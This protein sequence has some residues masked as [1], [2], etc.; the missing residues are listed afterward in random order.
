MSLVTTYPFALGANT[1]GGVSSGGGGGTI[2]G[3]IQ[4][5]EVAFG[6]APDTIGG[7]SDFT[8]D[9]TNKLLEVEKIRTQVII[10]VRNETGVTI[11]AGSAVYVSADGS[12]IPLVALADASD[13]TK[14][15]SVGIVSNAINTG[16][17][18]Y[19]VLTGT[20]NGLD[21]SAGNTVF[22]S[23]IVVGDV[24]KTLYVSPTN[25]GRLTITRPTGTTELVQNV[26]RIIDLTGN[27]V[28]MAVNN[29][30]RTNDVPNSFS[31]TGNIDAGSL[32]VNSAFTFPTSDGASGQILVTDG[33][34]NLSF[35]DPS[36]DT[37]SL[38]AD[39]TIAI[40]DT[41]RFVTS[42]DVG[43][44]AGRVIRSSATTEASG[45]VIGIAK[46]S[47]IQGTTIQVSTNGSTSISFSSA[48]ATSDNGKTIYLSTTT[49]K[50]T[51]IAPTTTGN[52]IVKLGKVYGADGLSLTPTCLLSIDPIVI[53][54]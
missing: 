53:L 48:P 44:T 42:A 17:N 41:L 23:T 28:K 40:G 54:G 49:G 51:L 3:T 7:A 29:I 45:E 33:G 52:S 11:E 6:T 15:A 50:A 16:N 24:G 35:Q 25:A 47:G 19:A 39:E 14:M 12:S 31:T 26:G 2:N 36:T 38:V 4:N 21:G 22:D 34:G 10:Q 43:L 32:T 27:N 18:G 37:L 46:T 8:Y 30:G 20:I 13:S 5:T 9:T 1:S